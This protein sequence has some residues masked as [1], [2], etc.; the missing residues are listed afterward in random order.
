MGVFQLLLA[1]ANSIL[2]PNGLSYYNIFGL[3]DNLALVLEQNE[4]LL[5]S[6]NS[7]K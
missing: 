2:F 7:C 6:K 1:E 3:L 5:A 4:Q